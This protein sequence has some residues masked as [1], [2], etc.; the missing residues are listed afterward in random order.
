MMIMTDLVDARMRGVRPK[1]VADENAGA[2]KREEGDGTALV[3]IN[4]GN[5]TRR[6]AGGKRQ[7]GRGAVA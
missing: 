2:A 7:T 4:L 3:N 6:E 5:R 1:A